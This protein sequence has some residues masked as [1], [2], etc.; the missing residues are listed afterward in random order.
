MSLQQSPTCFGSYGQSAAQTIR[1]NS[2]AE[3]SSSD[4]SSDGGV[5]LPNNQEDTPRTLP[6]ISLS[7]HLPPPEYQFDGSIPGTSACSLVPGHTADRSPPYSLGRHI[8]SDRQY[9]AD[10]LSSRERESDVDIYMSDTY[11]RDD[12]NHQ[13]A[14]EVAVDA[15]F[16]IYLARRQQRAYVYPDW[17]TWMASAERRNR[18]STL[19]QV[20]ALPGY[21]AIGMAD[22]PFELA[23]GPRP[24]QLI[25]PPYQT[26]TAEWE[27]WLRSEGRWV[28]ISLYIISGESVL[29]AEKM[30]DDDREDLLGERAFPTP[31][32]HYYGGERVRRPESRSEDHVRHCRFAITF[33]RAGGTDAFIADVFNRLYRERG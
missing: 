24:P 4:N 33:R 6:N 20:E 17:Q 26:T 31:A 7:P 10:W 18:I 1:S 25:S 9:W 8:N 27:S 13:Q 22:I 19:H 21:L 5:P 32:N 12:V 14:A 2:I 30:A 23:F 29:Q 11:P 16:E 15:Q 3:S 28:A